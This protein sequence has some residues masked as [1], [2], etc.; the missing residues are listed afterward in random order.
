MN[1]LEILKKYSDI[2]HKLTQQNII[3]YLKEDHNMNVDRK[4]I[5]RNLDNLIDEGYD[6]NY[7]EIERGKGKNKNKL[8]T[9]YYLLREFD[10]S[11]LRLLIDGLIFSKYIPYSQCKEL[12]EKLEGL[13]NKY[14]KSRVSNIYLLN[15]DKIVN[16]DLFY[17]IDIIDEAIK[18][19]KKIIF[20]HCEYN[21]KKELINKKNDDGSDKIYT[22]NPYHMA[23][24]N[25]R[26]YLICTFKG[27]KN[28][29]NVRLDRIKNIKV[30]NEK[31]DYLSEN[32][33]NLPKHMCEHLYMLEGESARVT[34]EFPEYLL[35]D[36][37]DWFGSNITFV[38]E[39]G[40][41][42][43]GSANVNLEGMKYWALQYGDH[44][45]VI[46]PKKLV[47]E[48]KKSIKCMNKK[49]LKG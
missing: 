45:K 14:F 4:S 29:A 18:K 1:I 19:D 24:L 49:Y 25:G 44:V 6:I 41:K 13:S 39:K 32:E 31:R 15:D 20:S 38:K 27:H 22:A 3:K 2:D 35:S 34:F 42:I 26:Y 9:N 8:R 5:K 12:V 10:N 46:S 11:E 23:A 21:I 7:D 28:I 17:N 43:S 30:I 16:K 48:I 37:I 47:D 40:D 36:V 33:I